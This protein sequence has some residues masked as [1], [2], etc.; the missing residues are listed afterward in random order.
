[1]LIIH[2]VG[3]RGCIFDKVATNK[4]IHEIDLSN[5]SWF[6]DKKISCAIFAWKKKLPD[7]PPAAEKPESKDS[8]GFDRCYGTLVSKETGL[9]YCHKCYYSPPQK[10]VEL[11]ESEG[12]CDCSV[13]GTH[14]PNPNWNP[15]THAITDFDPFDV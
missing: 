9:R 5:S 6:S 13:C 15:P 11:R 12:G 8:L 4:F 2:H 14:Y 7:V 10:M 1:L 3:V